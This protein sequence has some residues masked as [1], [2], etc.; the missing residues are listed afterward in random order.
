M[1]NA[2]DPFILTLWVG[3]QEKNFLEAGYHVGIDTIG[4]SKR[5][6]NRQLRPDIPNPRSNVGPWMNTVIDQ[7]INISKPLL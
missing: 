2:F 7:D 5:N 3:F 6:A 1:S 4:A